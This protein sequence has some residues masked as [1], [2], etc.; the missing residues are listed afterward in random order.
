MRIE[1]TCEGG[2]ATAQTPEERRAEP[3]KR[4][5]ILRRDKFDETIGI[6]QDCGKVQ[7]AAMVLSEIA[8][9]GADNLD[10]V[11]GTQTIEEPF[12]HTLVELECHFGRVVAR[13]F[14]DHE[15]AEKNLSKVE[16]GGRPCHGA[17]NEPDDGH[18]QRDD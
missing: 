8:A 15:T 9:H 17:P 11:R 2:K 12:A 13:G 4:K 7:R 14:N 3:S 5:I 10:A 6:G 18:C 1:T 16:V